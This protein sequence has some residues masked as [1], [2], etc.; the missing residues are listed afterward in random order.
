MEVYKL[1][2]PSLKHPPSTKILIVA[3]FA[4]EIICDFNGLSLCF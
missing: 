4:G 2:A 1:R 3:I